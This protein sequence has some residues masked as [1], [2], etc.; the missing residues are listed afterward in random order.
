[1]EDQII[2]YET[3]VL[4]KEK[5]F[6]NIQCSTCYCVGFKTIKKNKEFR[7][8]AR[9]TVG[10]QHH[11]ALAPTQSLLATWIREK[12]NIGIA[13]ISHFNK[14]QNYI[15]YNINSCDIMFNVKPNFIGTYE[16]CLEKALFEALN[17]IK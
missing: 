2:F 5:G 10:K 7:G 14:F 4:A 9:K 3:A 13:I 16:E 1:M 12:H 17:L 8:I 15:V 6:D 11:L